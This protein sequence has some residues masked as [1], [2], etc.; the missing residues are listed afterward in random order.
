MDGTTPLTLTGT[1]SH[2]DSG[3]PFFTSELR[4]GRGSSTG[5]T[6]LNPA[7]LPRPPKTEVGR[8]EGEDHGSDWRQHLLV[9]GSDL[10]VF[11]RTW[12]QAVT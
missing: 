1:S 6:L 9:R 2:S 8:S 10:G 12:A 5:H 7:P 3:L 11:G 4:H